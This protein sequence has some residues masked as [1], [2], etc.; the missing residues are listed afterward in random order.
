MRDLSGTITTGG[1]AQSLS[2][3]TVRAGFSFYNLSDTIMYLG[4]NRVAAANPMSLKIP[5]GLRYDT[6]PDCRP[7]GALSVFCA[8]A[9]KAFTASEW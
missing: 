7:D 5:P 3:G 8:T 9:G 4:I 1:Q 2:T 6:P